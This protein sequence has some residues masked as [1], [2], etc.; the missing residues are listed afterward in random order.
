MLYVTAYGEPL[1]ITTAILPITTPNTVTHFTGL[2]LF[3]VSSP[4]LQPVPSFDTQAN[5]YIWVAKRT[6]L[7]QYRMFI[8]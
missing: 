2:F 7:A 8:A 1:A 5:I 4:K 3:T 6:S